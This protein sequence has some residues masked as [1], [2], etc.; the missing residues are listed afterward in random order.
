MHTRMV[1]TIIAVLALAG[2]STAQA[3][4]PTP[5][6]TPAAEAS[7]VASPTD[8][9]SKKEMKKKKKA[10]AKLAIP[11]PTVSGYIQVYYKTRIERSGD[12]KTE[13]DVIRFGRVKV[14][15]AGDVRPDLTY[16][17]EI[18]PR[19]P[20]IAGVVR[21]AY[22]QWEFLKNQNLRA[23]QFKTPFGWEN[24]ESSA[25]LY[26]ANRTEVGEGLGR[27]LTLRDMGVG[28]FGRIP[29]GH[30]FRLENEVTVTNGAGLA[31]QE[32]DDHRKN[33]FGRLGGRW[34]CKPVALSLGFSG[35]TGSLNEPADPVAM[36]L[37][38]QI[39][40]KRLGS[41]VEVDSPWAF[42][43]AE[44]ARGWEEESFPNDPATPGENS[45][46]EAWYVLVAGKT[47]WKVG[48]VVRFDEFD[49]NFRRWTVGAYYGLPEENLRA[50]LTYEKFEE[51]GDP[52]DD[53]VIAW[54]QVRF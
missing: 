46:V 17:V 19:S 51:D 24:R 11:A 25:N 36:D 52:H 14:Q 40:F 12:E 26:T 42:A 33:V 18:D 13:P 2:S 35:A 30:G 48:P 10:D 31:A 50:L 32:D 15:V 28:L 29:L 9:M 3:Q 1:A 53:R 16:V 27:G 38:V 7:P 49:Q 54:T 4:E 34:K 21:D 22:I 8:G 23:G 6:S 47:P 44:Y 37:A 41:D 20:Q 5:T 45:A 39:L 43:V